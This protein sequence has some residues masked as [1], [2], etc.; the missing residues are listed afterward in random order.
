MKKYFATFIFLA[1]AAIFVTILCLVS[2]EPLDS[3]MKPPSSDGEN[4]EIQ[5]VFEKYI[6]KNYKLRAPL[7][8]DYRSAFIFKD[9]D[10]DKQDEVFVFY[11]EEDSPETVRFCYLAKADGIWSVISDYESAY[12]EILKVDFSDVNSDGTAEMLVGWEIYQNDLTRN[13]FVYS[14]G[15]SATSIYNCQYSDYYVVD[16]DSNGVDDI[17]VFQNTDTYEGITFSVMS[18]LKNNFTCLDS[19]ELDASVYSI[20]SVSFER[21]TRKSN[22]RAYIDGYKT[23]SGI[24]TECVYWDYANRC[25]EKIKDINGSNI[26]SAR[27]TNISCRDINLDGIFEIPVEEQL[28]D[29]KIITS[30]NKSPAVQSVIKWMQISKNGFLTISTQLVYNNNDFAV[31]FSDDWIE[32]LTV[33][34]DYTKGSIYFYDNRHSNKVLLFELKYTS[35]QEEED[36]LSDRYK[37]LTE[38]DKGKLFFIIYNHD[39]SLNINRAYIENSIIR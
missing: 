19:V 38:T 12:S 34:N 5:Q 1:V 7:H 33:T 21:T 20:K 28:A 6:D 30:E 27:L 39:S 22:I 3:L 2:F 16:F 31:D 36:G 14:L 17:A 11:S 29:S 25:L 15:K 13:L 18:C 24:V 32:N 23:D 10:N 9:I 8:G 4:L 26:L 37:L 35:N